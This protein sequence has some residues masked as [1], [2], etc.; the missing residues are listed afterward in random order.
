MMEKGV[1]AGG[2]S[3]NSSDFV[4][5]LFKMLEDPTY[6][7][8]VRWAE[9]GETFVV[10]EQNEK[11]T[12]MV[13]PKHFKHSN[14]A[15][16]VRQL[17][18]Y[19]F[20]KVRQNSE[21]SAPSPYGPNAWE[22][23]HPEFQENKKDLLDNIKRKA[24][25][26]RKPPPT[27]EEQLPNQQVDIL[28]S[29]LLASQQQIQ[30]LSD[31]YND[32]AQSQVTLLQQIVQLQ[33]F[34][35]NHEGVM[36]R[37]MGFLHSVDAQRRSSRPGYS[38]GI[39]NGDLPN[40]STGDDHVASPLQQATELLGK[41]SAENL[42][43]KEL[44]QMTNNFQMRQDY[45]TSP[46]DPTINSLTLQTTNQRIDYPLGNDLENLVYPVGNT[47]GIDPIH[48][49]HIHNIPYAPPTS[50]LLQQ[51]LPEM[52]SENPITS[53][54]NKNGGKSIWG[55]RKP[56]ILLVEDDKICVR[57]GT[58]FLQ[59][60]D[61]GV[62]TAFD[63]MEAVAK[64]NHSH[65][66]YDL[67]LMDII[68]PRLDGVSATVC[69]KELHPNLSIIAMT[70]NIRA[71]DI[72]MYFS[73]GMNGVL[74]KPFTKEGMLRSLEKHLPSIFQHRNQISHPGE[75]GSSTTSHQSHGINMGPISTPQL[76]TET[77]SDKLPAAVAPWNSS[78]QIPVPSPVGNSSARYM[79]P[80]IG[81]SFNMSSSLSHG[82]SGPS[83]FAQPQQNTATS[84]QRM[85]QRRSHSEIQNSNNDGP[86]DKRQRMLPLQQGGFAP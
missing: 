68:M 6:S 39:G 85:S 36:Q 29:Q 14:F 19:D 41:F 73:H 9:G 5:K 12:K 34:V 70:S 72:E 47:N 49:E 32:L 33:K 24:P 83:N 42:P 79:R 84:N 2:Q 37:V 23:K 30:N 62:D 75:Y 21:D 13:L 31:R 16:F 18:K 20:H 40:D 76:K 4:R 17:N 28:Y 26:P 82:P 77:Q 45:S 67:I 27:S 86:P 38:S 60:F 59:A 80:A 58:K 81:D 43:N 56:N 71:D 25:A 10:L 52:V 53:K 8:I 3:N 64:A 61:C 1:D 48:S 44:E 46:S 54:N 55:D 50:I 22:F 74:P 57:I 65:A 78:N 15:S 11:F 51:S 7:E 69:I 63:G 35:K 66:S